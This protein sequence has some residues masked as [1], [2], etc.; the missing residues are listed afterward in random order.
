MFI[1][2]PLTIRFLCFSYGCGA[3]REFKNEDGTFHPIQKMT[4]QWNRQWTPAIEIPVSIRCKDSFKVNCVRPF[5]H[6]LIDFC[7][8]NKQNCF[9]SMNLNH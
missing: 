5:V 7:I 4:C 9:A 8:V 3:G 6:L 2:I 1:F